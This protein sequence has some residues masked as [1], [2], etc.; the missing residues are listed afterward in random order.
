MPCDTTA[1]REDF[2]VLNR[3]VAG[4]Q[5]IYFDNAATT[6]TPEQVYSIYEDFY[7]RLSFAR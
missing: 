1:I 2:P 6:H 4:S 3:H 5:L 7:T